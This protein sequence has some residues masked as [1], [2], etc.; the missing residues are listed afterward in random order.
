MVIT[1]KSLEKYTSLGEMGEK[2][3]KNKNEDENKGI[4]YQFFP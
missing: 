2:N 3:S 4:I 1:G